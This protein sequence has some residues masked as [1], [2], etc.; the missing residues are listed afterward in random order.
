[1]TFEPI[2]L[3]ELV[4]VVMG[5]AIPLVVVTGLMVRFAFR[6]IAHVLGQTPPSRL[7]ELE[8]RVA[9][10]ERR[11]EMTAGNPVIEPQAAPRATPSH[12]LRD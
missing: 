3:N 12:S 8:E 11:L 6:P 4:G 9:R 2:D 5:C 10:L 1:M 7:H